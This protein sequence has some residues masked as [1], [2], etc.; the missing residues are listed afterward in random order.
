MRVKLLGKKKCKLPCD[1]TVEKVDCVASVLAS[2]SRKMG[3]EQLLDRKYLL[4]RLSKRLHLNYH[5]TGF[6]PQTHY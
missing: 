3:Q 1:S 6:C 2:S 5:T 4:H